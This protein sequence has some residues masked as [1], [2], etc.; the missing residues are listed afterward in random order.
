LNIGQE[1]VEMHYLLNAAASYTFIL[2][3]PNNNVKYNI[4]WVCL[5]S[6]SL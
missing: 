6:L 2:S 4:R 1:T 5:L 3:K